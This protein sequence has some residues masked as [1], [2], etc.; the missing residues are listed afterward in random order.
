MGVKHVQALLADPV[1]EHCCAMPTR[2][3]ERRLRESAASKANP[4]FSDTTV[5]PSDKPAKAST[6]CWECTVYG[7]GPCGRISPSVQLLDSGDETIHIN[8][9]D[10]ANSEVLGFAVP[11]TVEQLWRIIYTLTADPHLPHCLYVA[12]GECGHPVYS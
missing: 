12:E 8:G 2:I 6:C 7:R 10:L 5:M 1:S 9:L 4:C 11:P 3:L